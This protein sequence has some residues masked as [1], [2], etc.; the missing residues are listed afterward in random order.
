MAKVEVDLSTFPAGL[1][2]KE[3][4]KRPELKKE[5]SWFTW[6]GVVGIITGV[7]GFASFGQAAELQAQGYQVNMGFFGFFAIL[8]VAGVVLGI[9]LLKNRST[10]IAYALAAVGAITA[11]LAIASGGT[12]GLGIVATILSVIGARRIDRLWNA[13]QG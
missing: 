10:T 13:Y 6:A 4:V 2:K 1:T 7:L 5:N 8:S 11:V 9:M 3:F 12:I